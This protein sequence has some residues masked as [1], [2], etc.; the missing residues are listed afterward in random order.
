MFYIANYFI[1]W[2]LLYVF[3]LSFIYMNPYT[4]MSKICDDCGIESYLRLHLSLH[5]VRCLVKS[6]KRFV[7]DLATGAVLRSKK[8]EI[9]TYQMFISSLE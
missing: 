1:A 3:C 7:A 6:L 2:N 8:I 9:S 5:N 4:L